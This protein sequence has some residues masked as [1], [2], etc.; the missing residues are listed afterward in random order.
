MSTKT[1]DS[2][3]TKFSDRDKE[4]LTSYFRLA[5]TIADFIGPHSEVVI[6]SFEN[7]EKSVVKIVNGHHTGRTLG[8]P[9]TDLG[10]RML[11]A[12][13]KTGEV[14]PK[15][16][17][18]Q[19][20]D[21]SLLKSTTCILMGENNRP[22]GMF[23]IN[24]NLSFPFPEII[25]TLMPDMG[26]STMAVSENFSSCANDVI[27]HALDHAI[28][29]I[30][31]DVSINLKGRNKAITKLL[32][33]NGIFELKEATAIVSDRLGITRHAIYKYLREFKS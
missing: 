9:I 12:Y 14:T 19:S 15:S 7:F 20:K 33:E 1:L 29:E 32:F 13:E 4:I 31:N 23:C 11:S 18:T 30:E 26:H 21:G 3:A 16:Y 25:K 22:I 27:D 2:L 24:M 5:D 10:L 8:S 28:T 17:F 6:H